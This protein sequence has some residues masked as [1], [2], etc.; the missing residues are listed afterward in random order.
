[1]SARLYEVEVRTRVPFRISRGERGARR[2]LIVEWEAGGITARGEAVADAF[3]G[4]RLDAVRAD[5]EAAL[6]LVPADPLALQELRARL[7]ERFPRGG[8]AACALDVLAHDR[9]A[10]YLGVPLYRLF[11]LDPARAPATSFSIGIAEPAEMAERAAAA[12]TAG[13]EVLKVKLGSED[14][15][16][17][18]RAIRERFAGT[19]RVDANA[20]WDLDRALAT[21]D[22]L[23][24]LGV[25]FVEQ[26]LDPGDVAGQRRLRERSPLPIVLDE[27]VVRAADVP[28]LAP[29]AHGVNVKLQKSGGIAEARDVIAAARAHGL[30]VMLG[31]RVETSVSIAA[32]AHLAPLADWADLD[33]NLLLADDPF[34][35][36]EVV[37]GRFAHSER[38]GLG[39]RARG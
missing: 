13:F 16:G 38:A 25:E 11:G 15:L 29:L 22:G 7:D 37:R 12:A 30:R 20:G 2:V 1:M 4:E 3:F 21:L 17:R 6:P 26:P 14:D 35:G 18:L 28:A 23:V 32:A 39:V 36:V 33:G 5:L 34:V 24:E 8:A 9:A 27:P 31:C 10:Q 19:L